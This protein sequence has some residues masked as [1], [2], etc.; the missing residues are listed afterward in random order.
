MSTSSSV[1]DI[2]FLTQNLYTL[3]GFV[4]DEELADRRGAAKADFGQGG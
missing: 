3:G 4:V 1:K 2:V